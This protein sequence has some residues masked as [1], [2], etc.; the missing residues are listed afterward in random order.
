METLDTT[1]ST[2]CA[3]KLKNSL[4]FYFHFP[5]VKY[6]FK[7]VIKIQSARNNESPPPLKVYFLSATNLG[8]K[9]NKQEEQ[10]LA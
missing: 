5:K 10:N 8:R 9:Q 6:Q 1:W 3:I 7:I 2:P 4:T